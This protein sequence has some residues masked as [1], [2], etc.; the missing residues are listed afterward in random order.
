MLVDKIYTNTIPLRFSTIFKSRKWPL[1][2]KVGELSGSPR[3]Y[4]MPPDLWVVLIRYFCLKSIN[5]LTPT[6]YLLSLFA[7]WLL[8]VVSLCP[9][10]D[11]ENRCF[12]NHCAFRLTYIFTTFYIFHTLLSFQLTSFFFYLRNFLLYFLQRQ[13]CWLKTVF[14]LS[15]RNIFHLSSLKVYL[16]RREFEISSYFKITF[17]CSY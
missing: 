10:R 11:W 4:S 13:V 17:H 16:V 2:Q 1:P 6:T 15:E 9:E 7:Q 5:P 12:Y 3:N 14:C 8:Y